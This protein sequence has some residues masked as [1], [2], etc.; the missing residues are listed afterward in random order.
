[1]AIQKLIQHESSETISYGESIIN[2]EC[3]AEAVSFMKKFKNPKEIKHH[4]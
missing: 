4:D 3:D 2:I 1:M